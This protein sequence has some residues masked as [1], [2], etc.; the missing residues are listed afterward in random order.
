M[1]FTDVA[2]LCRYP[3]PSEINSLF[4]RDDEPTTIL[5]CTS[6]P[7]HLHQQHNPAVVID[8]TGDTLPPPAIII[9][10]QS[11]SG[12]VVDLTG[13]PSPILVPYALLGAVIDL[14][15]E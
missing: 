3:S 10:A 13:P 14:T 8:L 5:N 4:S 1:G 7:P 6:M 2:N 9:C 15:E 11:V 12:S